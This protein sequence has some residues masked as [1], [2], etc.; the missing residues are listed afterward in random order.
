MNKR[1]TSTLNVKTE[2]LTSISQKIDGCS[3]VASSKRSPSYFLLKSDNYLE[4]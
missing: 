4:N 1:R 2:R 3:Y